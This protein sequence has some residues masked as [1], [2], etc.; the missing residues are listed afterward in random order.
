MSP[1]ASA[2]AV[3]LLATLAGLLYHC[4]CDVLEHRIDGASET[5]SIV[6]QPAKNLVLALGIAFA[7]SLAAERFDPQEREAAVLRAVGSFVVLTAALHSATAAGQV[8][9]MT[10][11]AM[12]RWRRLGEA[13]LLRFHGVEVAEPLSARSTGAG[14]A[15]GDGERGRRRCGRCRPRCGCLPCCGGGSDD[16]DAVFAAQDGTESILHWPL[17][18]GNELPGPCCTCS[19]RGRNARRAMEVARWHAQRRLFLRSTQ[20]PAHFD[21]AA[22]LRHQLS[23]YCAV[24]TQPPTPP[25]LDYQGRQTPDRLL[26][27]SGHDARPSGERLGTALGRSRPRCCHRHPA[28]E[29]SRCVI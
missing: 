15:D 14:D 3:I 13:A 4:V 12:P 16:S 21:V 22:Y 9:Y 20:L 1:L 29:R 23:Q 27:F 8:L 18:A 19:R 25:Q 24:R 7:A 26:V 6:V 5:L 10:R 28:P 17:W 2:P 11:T